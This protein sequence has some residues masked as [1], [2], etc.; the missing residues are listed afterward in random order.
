MCGCFLAGFIRLAWQCLRTIKFS[1]EELLAPIIKV[2]DQMSLLA[3][4]NLHAEFDLKEDDSEVGNM[5]AAIHFM[6]N[7][8]TAI[9][10]E[11][12][13][14]LEQ[15]GQGN[16]IITVQQNYVGDYVKI[17]DSLNQIVSDMR[18]TVSMIQDVARRLTAVPASLLTPQMILRQHV[19]GRRQRFQI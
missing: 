8:M 13:S 1:Q 17:K 19:P 11:I 18:N 4:G 2:A 15:M 16:Y 14:V 5:V 12:S 7:N 9:I 6:K 3:D 10:D